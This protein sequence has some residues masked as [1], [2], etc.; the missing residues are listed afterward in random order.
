MENANRVH[1]EK[2]DPLDKLFRSDLGFHI[3]IVFAFILIISTHFLC[4]LDKCEW[5]GLHYILY[6]LLIAIGCKIG[7]AM[8]KTNIRRSQQVLQEMKCE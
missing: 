4:P 8:C 3:F 1:I 5:K 6:I 7:Y 2:E